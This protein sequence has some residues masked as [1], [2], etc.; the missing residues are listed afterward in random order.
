MGAAR[1]TDVAPSS[2]PL[3]RSRSASASARASTRPDPEE[4][5]E[6][7]LGDRPLVERLDGEV[8]VVERIFVRPLPRAGVE[9]QL[10]L[11][12]ADPEPPVLQSVPGPRREQ[13][14]AL[15]A[16]DEGLDAHPEIVGN[17]EEVGHGEPP[18][19]P[20]GRE[21]PGHARG[22]EQEVHRERV[23]EPF[24]LGEPPVLVVVVEDWARAVGEE[25]EVPV[26]QRPPLA[27]GPGGSG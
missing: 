22:R 11:G 10:L 23:G 20:V 21:V 1:S 8:L 26:R 15:E 3:D 25:V 19:A 27:L 4:L 18:V 6:P 5:G 7:A 9:A 14:E 13:S 24:A 12:V 16:E 2:S 17:G